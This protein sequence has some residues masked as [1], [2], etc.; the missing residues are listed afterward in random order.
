MD[1]TPERWDEI[2]DDMIYA[3]K[4]CSLEGDG[5]FFGSNDVDWNRVKEGCEY[6]GKYLRSL[7]W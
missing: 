6:F 7:W 4:I 1:L 3:M 2:L 5:R